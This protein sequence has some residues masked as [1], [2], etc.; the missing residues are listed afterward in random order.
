MSRSFHQREALEHT[1][2]ALG[3]EYAEL[4]KGSATPLD[5]SLYFLFRVVTPEQIAEAVAHAQESV[6]RRAEAEANNA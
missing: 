3:Y 1:L 5:W 4:A 2:K 6:S